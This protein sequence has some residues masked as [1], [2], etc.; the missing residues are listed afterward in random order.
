[1]PA[2]R[3]F[4]TSLDEGTQEAE[5]KAHILRSARRGWGCMGQGRVI[6]STAIEQQYKLIK[7]EK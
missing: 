1:M 6:G 4:D 7:K 3:N 2:L 5:I